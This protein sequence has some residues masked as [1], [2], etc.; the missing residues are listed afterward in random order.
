[1]KGYFGVIEQRFSS[2]TVF[3]ANIQIHVRAERGLREE[4]ENVVIR[5]LVK[6]LDIL[7]IVTVAV[8]E[9]AL[10]R[11]HLVVLWGVC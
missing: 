11:C 9:K 5:A 2:A 10:S 4:L 3:V 7:C 8:K 1:V 6:V